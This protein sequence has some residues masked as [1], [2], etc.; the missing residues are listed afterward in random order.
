MSTFQSSPRGVFG[1]QHKARPFITQAEWV[2]R[3]PSGVLAEDR[4]YADAEGW[5]FSRGE[6]S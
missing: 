1:K 5:S 6:F 2:Q 4:Y 3:N